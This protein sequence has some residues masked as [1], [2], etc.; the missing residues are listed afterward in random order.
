MTRKALRF[1]RWG[2]ASVL[3]AVLALGAIAGAAPASAVVCVNGA[4]ISVGPYGT[5]SSF[6]DC[7]G[8]NPQRPTLFNTQ[9]VIIVSQSTANRTEP[10]EADEPSETMGGAQRLRAGLGRVVQLFTNWNLFAVQ[11]PPLLR[12]DAATSIVVRLKPEGGEY[13]VVGI[14]SPDADGAV[15]LP[16]V[17]FTRPGLYIYALTD[18]AGNLGY[19]KV[20][21]GSA[22][23]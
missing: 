6:T 2:T 7:E 9:N 22:S 19:I 23:S 4:N 11:S 3:G 20:R 14:I 8:S 21:V 15:Q 16:A 1:T 13:A 17:R 5:I 10:T 12:A 18:F